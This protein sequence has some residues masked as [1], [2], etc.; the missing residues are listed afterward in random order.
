MLVT[1]KIKLQSP[2]LGHQRTRDKVR[3]FRK[4]PE[5][6]ITFDH[7]QWNFVVSEAVHH[8][9]LDVNVDAVRVPQSYVAP[10]LDMYVRRW[11]DNSGAHSERFECIK[12][13]TVITFQI[14]LMHKSEESEERGPDIDEIKDILQFIGQWIGMSPW[15]SK[16]NYGRFN[17]LEVNEDKYNL[18]RG[19]DSGNTNTSGAGKT[20]DVSGT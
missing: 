5:G 3:V 6:H 15:G 13:G 18:G 17:V 8:L 12:T 16:F 2:F 20:T 11:V 1:A 7:A 9:G 4:T 19:A 10:R 14:L